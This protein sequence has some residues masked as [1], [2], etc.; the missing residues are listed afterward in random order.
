MRTLLFVVLLISVL[1]LPVFAYPTYTGGDDGQHLYNGI[2]ND[3]TYITSPYVTFDM[4]SPVPI[5]SVG[6]HERTGG[7]LVYDLQILFSNDGY[8]GF[9]S[10]S[11]VMDNSNVNHPA[12]LW[13]IATF[14]PVTA[15]YCRVFVDSNGTYIQ[16][17]EMSINGLDGAGNPVP[18]PSSLVVLGTLLIPFLFR[19]RR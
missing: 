18:E 8:Y 1:A 17:D 13:A 2:Y 16:A 11:Y 7:G 9:A 5:S 4:G 12:I 10:A 6:V 3:W 15:R 19:R 14:E